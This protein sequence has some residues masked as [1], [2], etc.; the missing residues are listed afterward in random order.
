MSQQLVGDW[1]IKLGV[2]QESKL[3]MTVLRSI[4]ALLDL[5][6]LYSA[7]P[8][9]QLLEGREEKEPAAILQYLCA[10]VTSR[11]LAPC[12]RCTF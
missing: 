12:L 9:M 10:S 3:G 7:P 11:K 1:F 2:E 6:L 5:P 8:S 4:L